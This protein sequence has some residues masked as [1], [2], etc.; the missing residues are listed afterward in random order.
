MPVMDGSTAAIQIRK[1]HPALPIIAQT[2]HAAHNE[3]AIFES[4]FDDYIT[5]PFTKE[6][7]RNTLRKFL[8]KRSSTK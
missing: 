8:D 6:K 4:A 3:I 2:A 7:I 1:N 5:K